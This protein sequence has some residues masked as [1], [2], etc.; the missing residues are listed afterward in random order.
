MLE[1]RHT[2]NICHMPV[3][4]NNPARALLALFAGASAIGLAPIFVRL[5]ELGP[6]ATAFYRLLLALP[7]LGVWL[8][9]ENRRT[10]TVPR[11]DRKLLLAAGLFFAADL[12][13]WHWS[14]RFTTVANATL[15]ANSAPLFVTLASWL[16]FGERIKSRFLLGMAIAFSGAVLLMGESVNLSRTRVTGDALGLL[17]AVFYAGYIIA[18]TRL[19]ARQ[20]TARVMFWSGA[21]CCLALLPVAM[22]SGEALLPHTTRGW[23]VLAGL[24]LVSHAGGQSLIAYALAHLPATF[25][26]V[27][28][29]WQTV[30]AALLAWLLLAEPL[31]PVQ[32]AGGVVVLAGILLARRTVRPVTQSSEEQR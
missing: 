12:A 6:V 21:V 9:F 13:V 25:S 29:L 32:M 24:A 31:S 14:I 18:V 19:R 8:L 11:A 23:L 16:W 26:S 22:L 4:L 20:S 30:A 28:L 17:T 1:P 15:L 2:K 3:A 5:S 27:T 10:T 7:V